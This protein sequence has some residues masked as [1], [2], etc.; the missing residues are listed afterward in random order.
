MNR[1]AL[2]RKLRV[3]RAERR[4]SLRDVEKLTGVNK[5]TISLAERGVRRPYDTTL[6]K[7][8]A[9]Y[10][11]PVEELFEVEGSAGKA[12]APAA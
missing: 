10:G 5:L 9:G 11:V 2:A 12:P 6:A 3:L 8:A 4:M 1:E 7:L